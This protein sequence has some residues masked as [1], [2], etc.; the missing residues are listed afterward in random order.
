MATAL[1]LVNVDSVYAVM[2]DCT[3]KSINA[4]CYAAC[5]WVVPVVHS[6]YY[7]HLK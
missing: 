7:L 5:Y 4:N 2:Q 1:A 3:L 6:A